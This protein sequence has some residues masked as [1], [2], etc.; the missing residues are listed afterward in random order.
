M[1]RFISEKSGIIFLACCVVFLLSSCASSE[2]M[3]RLSG[4]VISE[5]SAPQKHRLRKKSFQQKTKTFSSDKKG[6]QHSFAQKSLINIWPFF[7]RS[8]DYFSILWPFIDY[9]KYGFAVRP[10]LNKEGEDISILFPLSNWNRHRK[11]GGY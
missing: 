3:S 11:T 5:Y 7:F 10:I 4:G 2:R 6:D 1:L 8:D 9:D